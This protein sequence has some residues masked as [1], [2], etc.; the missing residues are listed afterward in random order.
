M[1]AGEEEP[2][3]TGRVGVALRPDGSE[4]V[5]DLDDRLRAGRPARLPG[6]RTSDERL[7]IMAGNFTRAAVNQTTRSSRVRRLQ[8][9]RNGVTYGRTHT[10]YVLYVTA[11]AV[12]VG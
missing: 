8:R 9:R 10:M 3:R 11:H 7:L 2:N 4:L 1:A 12:A 5:G 6:C